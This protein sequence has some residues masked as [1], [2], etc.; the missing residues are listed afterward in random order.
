MQ[1]KHATCEPAP[2][3]V[4][5]L[6]EHI[7]PF[8]KDGPLVFLS[9]YADDSS[10]RLHESILCAGSFLGWARDFY[11]AGVDWQARLEK[12][13]IKYFRATE[14]E[15][16]TGEFKPKEGLRLD[17]A[18]A[19]ALMVRHDLEKIIEKSGIGCISASMIWNDFR[20]LVAEN[21]K[22][23]T[24]YGTD[25]V[26]FI[27]KRLIKATCTLLERDW[28]ETPGLKVAFTFDSHNRWRQAE[29]AYEELRQTDPT[30]ARRMLHAGH[31]DDQDYPAL[32]MAD[33]MAHE[34][35]F[36]TVSSLE[37]SSTERPV[38]KALAAHH[39][40]Y[41]MGVMGKAEMLADLAEISG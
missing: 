6:A 24:H 38:F 9:L 26:I 2:V 31:A 25:A 15:S 30:C 7:F 12:D 19:R 35:R 4:L 14:C 27:Y 40:I 36:K 17:E 10:D 8:G 29:E 33:L 32:Q 18:R 5:D 16:L 39:N 21:G 20:E 41:F 1:N 13:G 11:Y 37:E 28:S 34:A 22:A 23:R 3:S